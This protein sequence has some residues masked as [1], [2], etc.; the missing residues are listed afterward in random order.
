[1]NKIKIKVIL[2]KT[3]ILYI[4]VLKRFLVEDDLMEDVL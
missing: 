2:D 1:M 3:E 4:E